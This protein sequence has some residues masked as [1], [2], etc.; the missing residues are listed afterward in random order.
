MITDSLHIQRLNPAC[1]RE[2]AEMLARAFFNDPLMA[3]YLPDLCQREKL[4]PRVMQASLRYCLMYGEVWAAADLS[5][6]ACW[7]PPGRTNMHTWGLIRSGAGVVPLWFGWQALHK[8]RAIEAEIDRLH[9]RVAPGPH[10]YLL[11]LGVAPEKQGQGVGS[12]LIAPQ[13]ARVE[14]AGL[15]VYLETMTELDVAF[16]RK[17]GFE[18]GEEIELA[19]GGLRVWG[20]KKE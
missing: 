5:G 3:H 20:M 14:A 1:Q 12:R 8:V 4:L 2:A 15:P 11:V 18:V 17:N 9:H 19:G 6:A 13:L 10:W 16:Y 7:L